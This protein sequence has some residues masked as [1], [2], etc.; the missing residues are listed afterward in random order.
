M[1]KI[2]YNKDKWL[3]IANQKK[4]QDIRNKITSAFEDLVFDEG[5]HKYFLHE[6]ELPSVS[7]VVHKFQEPFDTDAVAIY[8]YNKYFND[9]SSKYYGKSVEDIKQMWTNM[10]DKA[11]EIG[12]ERHEFGESC[13]WYMTGQ[14]DKILPQFKERLT[15]DGGFEA[16]F[17]KE[18]A[19]IAFWNEIPRCMVPILCENK[20]YSERLGY[21]GTFD[22]LFYYDSSLND[23]HCNNSDG[24][25]IFDYKT[26]KKDLTLQVGNKMLKYCLSNLTDC[27][28][29]I[30][31][32]QLSLYEL[33]LKSIGINVIGRRLIWLRNNG[34]YNKL[35]LESY[36]DILEK[37]L[38]NPNY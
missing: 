34:V 14:L 18:E 38:L 28:L 13:F 12:T 5:P 9:K 10:S 25:V 17:P 35:Q 26:N 24:F 20:V 1:G 6:K 21:A 27:S 11:C 8:T 31:K 4:Y 36:A 22:I 7:M 32:A 16:R 15:K 19:V 2:L 29:N 33:C 37:F 23:T 3:D 30:Y